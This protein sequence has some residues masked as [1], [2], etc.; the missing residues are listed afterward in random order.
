MRTL[1]ITAAEWASREAWANRRNGGPMK[2]SDTI[3]FWASMRDPDT[4]AEQA[5]VAL[6]REVQ[7]LRKEA[8]RYIEALVHYDAWFGDE[9]GC[10]D[11][12]CPISTWGTPVTPAPPHCQCPACAGGVIHNSDCAVHAEQPS[13]FCSCGV[14]VCDECGGPYEF[15]CLVCGHPNG[16]SAPC[17]T[18][19]ER[20]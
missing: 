19:T 5:A 1:T 14:L 16:Q 4:P 3:A 8:S 13:E 2:L 11:D 15:G 18:I 10:S 17:K 6:A 20:A 7:R 12:P 9:C